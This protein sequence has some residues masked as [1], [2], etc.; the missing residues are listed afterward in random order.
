MEARIL[1]SAFL[2]S[3][4]AA[5][6]GAGH[7][8]QNFLVDAP[9][10]DFA[11]QVAE[12]A[13]TFRRDLAI[14]WLGHELPSWQEPCPIRVH[15]G[16]NLG[17]GGA[18]TFSFDGNRPFRW[19]M[20]I[21]GPPDRILDSVLPHEVTHTI[22][23]THFGRPLPRWADE[24]ASTTVEHESEISK[25]DQ[26][27]LQF[28]ASRPSRGIPFNRMFRMTEYPPDI[29]PL[30]SQGYSLTRFLIEQ[31][32]KQ[33][34]VRYVGEGMKSGN[35]AETT[36]Q[37]YGFA[38]LSEL[39]LA[40]NQW[41]GKGSPPLDAIAQAGN[42]RPRPGALPGAGASRTELASSTSA[43]GQPRRARGASTARGDSDLRF[44]STDSWYARTRDR[45]RSSEMNARGD[46][47]ARSDDL[48]DS[49]HSATRPQT[50][51]RA[52]QVILEWSREP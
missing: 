45:A 29:L 6:I 50:P 7:R 15:V 38:D 2:V 10:A 25:Q 48:R 1:R 52:E 17:S 18:T 3:I 13:E 30:Y 49:S 33:K 28:L 35:W 19:T 44:A 39:Q 24:G 16:R 26:L 46:T 42:E 4:A 47:P 36:R 40:W 31:G 23:A 22:F 41:V 12:S 37:L 9:T 14:E 5:S 43:T 51:Q 11:R 21:Q 20:S 8:T 32:G 34:F 27:L